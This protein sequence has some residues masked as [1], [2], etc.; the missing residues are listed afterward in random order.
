MT[1]SK[2]HYLD[3]LEIIE[4]NSRNSEY[5]KNQSKDLKNLIDA[6]FDLVEKHQNL[7]R[8]YFGLQRTNRNLNDTLQRYRNYRNR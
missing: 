8:V 7:E 4:K 2:G 3:C 1:Q 5:V 6:Y